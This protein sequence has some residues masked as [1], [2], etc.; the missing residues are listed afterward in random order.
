MNKAKAV[1]WAK[2]IPNAK[3]VSTYI[4]SILVNA[5]HPTSLQFKNSN[6]NMVGTEFMTYEPCTG[7]RAPVPGVMS[8]CVAS[9]R[10]GTRTP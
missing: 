10:T 7:D 8:D 1:K 5:M 2:E 4:V 9:S 3:N 6:N